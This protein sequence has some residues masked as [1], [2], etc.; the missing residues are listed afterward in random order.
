M[1][2]SQNWGG[3]VES[4]FFLAAIGT[5]WVSKVGVELKDTLLDL[6]D[7]FLF[8]GWALHPLFADWITWY[9]SK[10]VSSVSS[11]FAP[12]EIFVITIDLIAGSSFCINIPLGVAEDQFPFTFSN[13]TLETSSKGKAPMVE[14]SISNDL[15]LFAMQAHRVVA[16][17]QS[18]CRM[19][20]GFLGW[21]CQPLM[22]SSHP[23]IPFILCLM[24]NSILCWSIIEQEGVCL[25]QH[26]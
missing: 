13:F 26:I 14:L 19:F 17:L 21:C 18:S 9:L 4:L 1:V 6:S 5:V 11:K 25:V 20:L 16:G 24:D 3:Q 22:I 8:E 12:L 10:F 7:H 15:N 23:P 2:Q